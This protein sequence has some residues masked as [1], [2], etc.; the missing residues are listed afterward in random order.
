MRTLGGV[1]EAAIERTAFDVI[2]IVASA[3]GL[4]AISAVLSA[5]PADFP[6]ALVIV[7]H[8][9]PRQPSLMAHILSRVSALPV[10]QAEE[11]DAL[12][13]QPRLS[14]SPRTST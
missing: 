7:Q 1:G 2:A 5:L 3:G 6:A 9:S 13:P 8:L 11:G 14:R 12:L 4:K 10:K